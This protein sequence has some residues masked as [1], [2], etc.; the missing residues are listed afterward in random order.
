MFLVIK[1]L[2]YRNHGAFGI[3]SSDWHFAALHGRKDHLIEYRV[4][5]D[6][7]LPKMGGQSSA[8]ATPLKLVWIG[9]CDPKVY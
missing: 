9:K 2:V 1:V 7:A 5:A 8:K 6:G 4:V 3:W